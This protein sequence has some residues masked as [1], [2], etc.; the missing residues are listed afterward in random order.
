MRDCVTTQGES[1]HPFNQVLVDFGFLKLQ[2]SQY[3]MARAKQVLN[4]RKNSVLASKYLKEIE[5][6][7]SYQAVMTETCIQASKDFKA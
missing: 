7:Q 1:E 3:P 2:H 5:L 4:Q 6:K